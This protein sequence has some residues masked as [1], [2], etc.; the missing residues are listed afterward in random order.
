M[1]AACSS[2]S[3]RPAAPPSV[4]WS[5]GPLLRSKSSHLP[6]CVDWTSPWCDDETRMQSNAKA[7]PVIVSETRTSASSAEKRCFISLLLSRV[8]PGRKLAERRPAAPGVR[9]RGLQRGVAQPG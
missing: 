9:Y 1:Q 8:D 4:C 6:D 5:A 7:D 2:V 3:G